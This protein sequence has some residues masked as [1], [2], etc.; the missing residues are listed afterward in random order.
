M[1]DIANKVN[2]L[3]IYPSSPGTHMGYFPPGSN[4]FILSD[5]CLLMAFSEAFVK[6]NLTKEKRNK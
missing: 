2:V 6:V 3:I 4:I 5:C 1:V